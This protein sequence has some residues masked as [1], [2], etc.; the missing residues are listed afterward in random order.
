M[1]VCFEQFK[2]TCCCS[3]RNP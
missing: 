1:T 2:N 3:A